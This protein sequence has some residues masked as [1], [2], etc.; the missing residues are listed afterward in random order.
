MMSRE[1]SSTPSSTSGSGAGTVVM[2]ASL[3]GGDDLD[4][5]P[6][7]HRGAAPAAARD[8]GRVHGHGHAQAAPVQ[9]AAV[10]AQGPADGL[11]DEVDDGGVLGDD[12]RG[13]VEGDGGHQ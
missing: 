10:G 3:D 7:G 8:D 11:G 13:A 12:A 1:D 5:L 4:A 9:G 6:L 2:S